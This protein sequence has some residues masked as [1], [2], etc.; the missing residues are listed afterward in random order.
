MSDTITANRA[1]DGVV[2]AKA[3][4]GGIVDLTV[5]NNVVT[6]KAKAKGNT[7]VTV[8]VAEGTNHTAPE[9]KTFT[10]NVSLPTNTLKDNDWATIK[11][12][13]DAGT[14]KNYWAVGDVK[15]IKIDGKVGDYTFSNLSV[16]VFILGFDHNSEKEGAHKI[17]FQIGKIGTTAVALCDSHYNN[18]DTTSTGWFKMNTTATNVG[19]WESCTMRTTLLGNSKPPQALWQIALWR[20]YLPI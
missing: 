1:G 7:V 20:H 3:T 5:Q 4:T 2:S 6:V 11:A 16:D 15:N 13:S 18:Y 17:H 12:M 19:G 10:V 9:N 8:S 14:G